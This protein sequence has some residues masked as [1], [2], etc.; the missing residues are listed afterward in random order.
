MNYLV[1]DLEMCKVPRDYRSKRYKYANE[2]IQIGAVLLDEEFKRIGT[3]SQFVHPEHGVIDYFIENLTGIKNGQVKH[4]P[5][6]QEALLHMFNWIGDREYKVY[7][8]SGSDRAQIL[9]EI[10]A[11]NIVDEKIASFMEESRW[12]DYQD[13]FMKRYEMSRKMSLEE[14]LGRADIDPEG[15]FHDGL[16][17]A[18][19][20]GL[21]IE[22]LELNP[23]YQLVSY[24]MPEKPSEHFSSSL[25]ELF[26]GM[27]L[28]LA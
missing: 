14:A 7:A 19:N 25:G 22:K 2:T 11:K 5:R 17:D 3:L 18:V 28:K 12:V 15:R 16:N 23:D 21:L 1:I 10:K 4:A 9:H 26:A 27:E 24:E 13:I 20:T 8:W 6:L